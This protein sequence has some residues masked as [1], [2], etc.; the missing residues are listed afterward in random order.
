MC[1]YDCPGIWPFVV[2][3]ALLLGPFLIGCALPLIAGLRR[4][5]AGRGLAW[6]L[7]ALIPGALSFASYWMLQPPVPQVASLAIGMLGARSLLSAAP[8]TR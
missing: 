5:R 6:A 4:R 8:V 3:V 7:G 1:Q 2:V